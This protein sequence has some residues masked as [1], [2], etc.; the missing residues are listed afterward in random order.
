MKRLLSFRLLRF[1]LFSCP[2][3]VPAFAIVV[4]VFAFPPMFP[5][6]V[7]HLVLFVCM[8]PCVMFHTE[9]VVHV[10]IFSVG[11]NFLR[12]LCIDLLGIFHDRIF[13]IPR[14]R[15]RGQG[16]WCRKMRFNCDL[17]SIQCSPP[18][19][20]P[21]LP[22]LI[23]KLATVIVRCLPHE[24]SLLRNH[25]HA[26]FFSTSSLSA[27]SNITGSHSRF[28]GP[29]PNEEFLTLAGKEKVS[30]NLHTTTL[31]TKKVVT[32][33][34][35]TAQG[36]FTSM[37]HE[38][39]ILTQPLTRSNAAHFSK[40]VQAPLDQRLHQEFVP[41]TELLHPKLRPQKQ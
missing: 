35:I 34:K 31:E 26:S 41:T 28:C 5:A 29:L 22:T 12:H 32:K 18:S 19:T 16:D 8:G 21:G 40:R 20:S 25:R 24:E 13:R 27:P 38:Q 9:R 11:Y 39:T 17:R 1:V 30:T 14:S 23:L 3:P 37:F 4:L 7:C 6:F 15:Y 2:V 10:E 33:V 36:S